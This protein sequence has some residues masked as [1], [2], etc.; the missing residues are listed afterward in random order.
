MCLWIKPTA[1]GQKNEAPEVAARFKLEA[2]GFVWYASLDS[3]LNNMGASKEGRLEGCLCLVTCRNSLSY[4]CRAAKLLS[5]SKNRTQTEAVL[6]VSQLSSRME[7]TN[8]TGILQNWMLKPQWHGKAQE[9]LWADVSG[10][11]CLDLLCLGVCMGLAR[12]R[13]QGRVGCHK[14]LCIPT[15]S[16]LSHQ[17]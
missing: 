10:T 11:C 17:M 15:A 4:F 7:T 1:P 13:C 12:L 8:C 16:S 6:K 2:V 9:L 5:L 3:P 14:V